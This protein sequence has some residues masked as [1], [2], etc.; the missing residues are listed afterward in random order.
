MPWL[1]PGERSGCDQARA[2]GLEC[3]RLTGSWTKLRRFGLPVIIELAARG[4]DKRHAALVAI[5]GDHATLR[6]GERE[7]TVALRE[8]D[9][10]WEG[11]FILVWRPPP[12]PLPVTPGT[13][14]KAPE[15]L[16]ARL[17]EVDGDRG[18]VEPA[19][20]YGETLVR[21]VVAFQQARSLPADGIVGIETAIG[22]A[23]AARDP[24]WPWLAAPSH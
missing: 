20:T 11:S 7:A 1:E 21:R 3:L 18:G 12:I 6:L 16:S 5:D 8:I 19:G 9:P 22:L 24:G 10:F 17:A 15:W 4:G 23:A 2:H 13:R 14:G